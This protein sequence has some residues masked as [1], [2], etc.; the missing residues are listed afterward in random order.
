LQSEG[1]YVEASKIM[2]VLIPELQ[3]TL[4]FYEN[5]INNK[6]HRLIKELVDAEEVATIV[7]R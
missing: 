1:K 7:S 5:K 4:K 3:K 2:Y 6:K